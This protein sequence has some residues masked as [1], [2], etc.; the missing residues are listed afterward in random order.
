MRI[1]A[2]GFFLIGLIACS[3]SHL[4][5]NGMYAYQFKAEQRSPFGTNTAATRMAQ[6]TQDLANI[7]LEGEALAE[8]I[9]GCQ[10]IQSEW[11]DS[12]SQG[13]GGQIAAGALQGIGLG[14]AGSLIGN[15]GGASASSS[16]TATQSVV[17]H[18]KH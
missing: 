3:S 7:Q 18:G 16:A 9:K 8:A 2:L 14:V 4:L 10:W 5:P 15:G 13:Q 1:F 6:C 17:T 12:A 11:H